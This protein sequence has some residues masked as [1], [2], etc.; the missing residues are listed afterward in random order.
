MAVS[1]NAD[2]DAACQCHGTSTQPEYGNMCRI[3]AQHNQSRRHTFR[4]TPISSFEICKMISYRVLRPPPLT[5]LHRTQQCYI[6]SSTR[7]SQHQSMTQRERLARR[8]CQVNHAPSELCRRAN[9]APATTSRNGHDIYAK[10]PHGLRDA[11]QD[12]VMGSLSVPQFQRGCSQHRA[13]G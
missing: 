8:C 10:H 2:A 13:H 6:L 4:T 7:S 11:L 5:N 12:Q 3:K 9:V 1:T